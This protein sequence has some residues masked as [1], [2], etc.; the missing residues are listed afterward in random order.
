MYGGAHGSNYNEPYDGAS[1]EYAM[2]K[3]DVAMH[4]PTNPSTGLSMED[5]CTVALGTEVEEEWV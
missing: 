3:G 2:V 5:L 1:A 4:V